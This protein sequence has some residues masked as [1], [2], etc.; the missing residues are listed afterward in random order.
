MQKC[1]Q[2]YPELFEEKRGKFTDD[3]DDEEMAKTNKDTGEK[4]ES[5]D[6]VD[7]DTNTTTNQLNSSDLND[8]VLRSVITYIAQRALPPIRSLL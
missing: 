4:C 6:A 5:K 7:K 8:S 1:M 2:N 3:E